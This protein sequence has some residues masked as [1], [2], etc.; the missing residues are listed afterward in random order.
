MLSCWKYGH[1]AA[2]LRKDRD[3]RHGGAAETGNGAQELEDICKG[4]TDAENFLFQSLAMLLKLINVV[5]TLTKLNCLF[6]RNSTVYSGLN[7]RKRSFAASVHELCNVKM[8][9]GMCEDIFGNGTSR[10][11]EDIR[12]HII[13]FQVGHGEAVLRTVLLTSQHIRQLH[14][15]TN[16]A[17]QMADSWRRDKGRIDHVAHEQVADPFCV[18]PVSLVALLRFGVLGMC[19]CHQTGLFEDVKDRNPELAGRLHVDFLTT[20]LV[21]PESQLLQ[22]LGEGREAC[23][24]VLSAGVCVGDANAGIDPGLVNVQ[25]TAVLTKDF[26][27]GVPPARK[28]Q[29]RQG[30]AVRRNRVNF[31]RDKFTGYG[32]API[33]DA[34]RTA[35]TI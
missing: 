21:K 22:P 26:E 1:V 15:V 24:K 14:A 17:S 5:E 2:N 25:S 23:L 11:A 10:F 20:V 13:Q 35:D 16:E 33:I 30:L 29:S 28:L 19:Q 27:R 12:E 6:G 4:F 34:F 7:L 3:S 9:T 18:L 31:G 32:F 8:F